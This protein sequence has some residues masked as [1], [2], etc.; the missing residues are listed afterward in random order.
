VLPN[1]VCQALTGKPISVYGDGSQTRSFCYVDDLVEGLV[2]LMISDFHEPVNLGNPDEITVQQLAEE[3]IS[4]TG[5][6]SKIEYLPLP[7]DDPKLRQPDISRAKMLLNWQP[8]VD[9]IT[10]IKKTIPY[11]RKMLGITQHE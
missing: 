9:R 4:L 1:F 10:G 6:S 8:T 7:G 5:S 3:V 11:F 2:R